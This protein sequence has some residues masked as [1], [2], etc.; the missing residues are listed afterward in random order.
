[1][2]VAEVRQVA[3]LVK[4]Q[5]SDFFEDVQRRVLAGLAEQCRGTQASARFNVFLMR[6]WGGQAPGPWNRLTTTQLVLCA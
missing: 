4:R 5:R 1:M 6:M 3:C 2:P